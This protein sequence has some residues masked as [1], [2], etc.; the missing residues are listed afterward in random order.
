MT[1]SSSRRQGHKNVNYNEKD[2]DKRIAK[3]RGLSRLLQ[4]LSQATNKHR[5]FD[6]TTPK[7]TRQPSA[8]LQEK[9]AVENMKATTHLTTIVA[10]S[11][12]KKRTLTGREKHPQAKESKRKRISRVGLLEAWQERAKRSSKKSLQAIAIIKKT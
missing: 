4:K 9:E 3:V 1:R 8:H 10:T 2:E 5:P 11:K 12:V 6:S 7:E